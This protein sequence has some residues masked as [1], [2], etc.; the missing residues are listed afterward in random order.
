MNVFSHTCWVD[1]NPKVWESTKASRKSKTSLLSGYLSDRHS[2][3][4][5]QIA[6]ISAITFNP[7][8]ITAMMTPVLMVMVLFLPQLDKTTTRTLTPTT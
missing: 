2:V 7:Q 4:I 3:P 8:M 6:P 5:T 1:I